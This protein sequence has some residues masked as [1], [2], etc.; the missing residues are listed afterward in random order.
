MHVDDPN[1]GVLVGGE[2]VKSL[3]RRGG[4]KMRELCAGEEVKLKDK[5]SDAPIE[6]AI[7]AATSHHNS[8]IKKI[9]V[10]L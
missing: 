4:G 5:I 10:L 8:N 2:E 6:Y 3:L 1:I 9:R 7:N